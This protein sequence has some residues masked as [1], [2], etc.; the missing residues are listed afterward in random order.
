[1]QIDKNIP[2]PAQSFRESYEWA[3]LQVGDSVFFDNEEKGGGSNPAMGARL[4]GRRCGKKLIARAEGNGV[5]IW[6][7]A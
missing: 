4:W 3:A 2:I 5:R 6:R 1:M 7:V